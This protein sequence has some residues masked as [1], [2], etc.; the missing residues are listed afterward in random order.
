M[1]KILHNPFYYCLII[2]SATFF[3][4]S[5]VMAQTKPGSIIIRGKV[6]DKKDKS[7]LVGASVVE[8]DNEKRT[9]NGISTDINGNFALKVSDPT[10]KISVSIIGY[11]VVVLEI[12]GRT[13]IN[14]QLEASTSDLNEVAIMSRKTSSNGLLEIEER[15]S[16]VSLAKINAKVLAEMSAASIDQALQGRLPGVDIAANSGDPGAGMQIR[17]RGTSTI[18]GATDPLIV[19]DGMPYDTE[20]PTDFNFGTADE[21]GYAT[22]L[23]I[24]PSDIEE[25][26]V[27]KDAAA[28]AVWGSKAANGVLLI[29]TKR[30]RVGKPVVNYS[31]RGTMSRQPR[32]IPMLTGDQFSSLIPE[33]YMNA[34]GTPLNTQTVKEFQYDPRDPYYYHNYSNNTDWLSEITRAGYMQDHNISISGGGEKARYY[35]SVGYLGQSGTTIGTDLGRISTRINLDY[36]VSDRIRF[37]TDIAYTHND[38]NKNYTNARGV[39]YK[40]LPNMSVYEFDAAG[41]NK[42][43]YFSPIQ[44]IQGEYS[45]TYNPAAMLNAG[46]N[47]VLEERIVP[48]F[49]LQY[50]IIPNLFKSTFD[51]QF[52][53]HNTKNKTFLPQIA[54]GR[55]ITE[56]AVNQAFDGDADQFGITTKTNFIYTPQLGEKHNLITL[57]SFMSSDSKGTS[58]QEQTSNSASVELQDPT[59][60]S[61][62]QNLSSGFSQSRSVA[63]LINAQ[64]GF[65][66]RYIINV[67]LRGDGNS[68]FGPANRYGL[69]P[70]VSARWRI[71]GEPFME[72]FHFI[73]DL[74]LRGSYGQSGNAPRN[75]YSF[76]NVYGNFSSDYLGQPAVYPE[77]IELK[78]LKWET[79]TGRN[80]G[81]GLG[82][83]KN[84]LSLDVDLYV[85]RTTD[86]FFNDL[87]IPAISGFNS[88][89]MNVGT[90]DNRGWEINFRATPLRTK[91]WNV[92][93]SF[94]FARNVNVIRKI[95]EYYPTEQGNVANNGEYKR[96]LQANNPF[97]SF[98]GF[99]YKGVYTDG[100]ATIAK[101]KNG[102]S[103]VGLDGQ[104]VYMRFNYPAT[105]YIFKP[106]DAEYEDI[107]HDGNIDYRD[108]VYLGNG[109]P[110]FIGGFGPEITFKEN[111]K[112]SAFFSFRYKYDVVNSTEMATT[113]MYNYDNQSTAVLR[114]WRN[115]GDV[116]DIPRA[117]YQ[118]G[119]NWLG[120]D[121]YVEDA[122]FIRLRTITFR[123][124]FNKA[125]LT[126][127]KL[128]NLGVYMTAENLFTFTSYTGQDPEISVKGS[129]PFRVAT[130]GSMTPPTKNFVIG[131]SAGF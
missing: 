72:K 104:N 42:G 62:V 17:I 39:A 5:H 13:V 12:K 31:F 100:N 128:K 118:S 15:N 80:I 64:Y 40:K 101:D 65:L 37:R 2:L 67:G 98:Y 114:R 61:R 99:R 71:S 66:D 9:I 59:S 77:N 117:L 23:N 8:M 49:N 47:T 97:G 57:L 22:L 14:V 52:D 3:Q 126:K 51:I 94:N 19:V 29:T 18:N 107:N 112:L 92:D 63:A 46:V 24:A 10:H 89:D 103:L 1:K 90:L 79:I 108:V 111:F 26:S 95:S 74:S 124:N 88:I 86:L 110:K 131:I 30:G 33:E 106:G 41:N 21:Q 44:N 93:L 56:T 50:D 35:A 20:I 53:I 7:E 68:R 83:F 91:T 109:N 6:T 70:S 28:T 48:R 76:Y 16:T 130:D 32:A 34:T 96:I 73:D 54:T 125:F 4:Y 82:M 113:N 27:L 45:G 38:N 87:N 25:I 55:P 127:A 129:D 84:R 69:F 36:N 122:S 11:K 58:F 116:T 102:N 119:Y 81:L 78:N 123:Y 60:P 75:N 120:S 43:N 115:P 121:R 85:N 105:D